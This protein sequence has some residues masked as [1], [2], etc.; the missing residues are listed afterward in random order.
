M[1]LYRNNGDRGFLWNNGTCLTNYTES[2]PR[3]IYS[4]SF[5]DVFT[6]DSCTKLYAA[7]KQTLK[8]HAMSHRP[9]SF[10][11]ERYELRHVQTINKSLQLMQ[12]L[13]WQTFRSPTSRCTVCL[14]LTALVVPPPVLWHHLQHNPR[15]ST[16]ISHWQVD[17]NTQYFSSYAM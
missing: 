11:T 7:S 6:L 8:F 2:Y 3:R 5:C 17:D 12:C 16:D 15:L 1:Q 4:Y 10:I 9:S 14:S 13:L